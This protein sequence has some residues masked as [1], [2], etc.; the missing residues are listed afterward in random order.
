[1]NLQWSLPGLG[2]LAATRA[3]RTTRA[4]RASQSLRAL[5]ALCAIA[6]AAAS[7]VA[8]ATARAQQ[9]TSNAVVISPV[10]KPFNYAPLGV[11]NSCLV[12]SV[13]F[14]DA[15]HTP[16]LG[17][18]GGWVRVLQ[19]GNEAGNLQ[20]ISLGHAVAVC[21]VRDVLWMYDINFGFVPLG[22]P[23]EKRNDLAAIESEILAKYRLTKPKYIIY[24][25]DMIPLPV[26]LPQKFTYI[27]GNADVREATRVASEI[28]RHR[29]TRVVGFVYHDNHARRTEA[30]AAALFEFDHRLCVYF[31]SQG[32]LT[33]ELSADSLK[34]VRRVAAIIRQMYPG[35][36]DIEWHD[37]GPWKVLQKTAAASPPPARNVL[38]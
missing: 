33:T 15:F 35:A 34:D 4:A 9:K 13:R 21:L 27:T 28:G 16:A 23:A 10:T 32:T 26:Q 29:P 37:D 5:C 11:R 30:G 25:P 3:K 19:W 7:L 12:E 36:T 20:H 31:P 6:I 1:M 18:T 24:H 38:R 22:T 2:R 17:G 8:T 14:Y